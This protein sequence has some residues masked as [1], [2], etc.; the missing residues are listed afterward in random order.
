LALD[1]SLGGKSVSVPISVSGGDVPEDVAVDELGRT[2]FVGSGKNAN[3]LDQAWIA[4]LTASGTLDSEFGE[5][6]KAFGFA[7]TPSFA[8]R[9]VCANGKVLVWVSATSNHATVRFIREFDEH[10]SVVSDFGTGGDLVTP[11]VGKPTE[12]IAFGEG[13]LALTDSTSLP[14][15]VTKNGTIDSAF[16]AFSAPTGVNASVLAI[17]S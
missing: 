7:N 14:F 11:F 4:R 13:V 17:D 10:G 1:T 5:G 12:L 15:M 9:V 16:S 8:N 2:L 3:H 6:G